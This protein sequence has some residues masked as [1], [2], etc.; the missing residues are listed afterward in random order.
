M[1][2][3][4]LVLSIVVLLLRTDSRTRSMV[5]KAAGIF[6]GP[7]LFSFNV[8][9]CLSLLFFF[10]SMHCYLDDILCAHIRFDLECSMHYHFET[11]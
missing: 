9:Y 3:P 7:N 1:E 4:R 10:F 2:I 8:F 11:C 5:S 6:S